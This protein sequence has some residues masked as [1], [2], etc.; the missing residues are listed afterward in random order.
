M[1]VLRDIA[2]R[3]GPLVRLWD[4]INSLCDAQR[5]PAV[6]DDVVLFNDAL[7]LTASGGATLLE[8]ARDS[9]LWVTSSDER[10]LSA[11]GSGAH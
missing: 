5:C 3:H 6:R 10:L 9:L 11:E 4:P 2:A 1:G 8:G 7:H